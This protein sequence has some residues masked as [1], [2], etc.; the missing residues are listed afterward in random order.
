MSKTF[1]E[2]F[3]SYEAYILDVKKNIDNL[4]S[5]CLL[6]DDDVEAINKDL[7]LMEQ[8]IEAISIKRS[9]E[10]LKNWTLVEGKTHTMNF[11]D[12]FDLSMSFTNWVRIF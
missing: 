5:S 12:R 8:K 9:L 4:V 3:R 11:V 7:Q 10:M 2:T 6:S 1:E